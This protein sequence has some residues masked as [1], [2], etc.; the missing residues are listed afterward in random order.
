ML[1][2]PAI[3]PVALS[4]GPLQ[5]HWY[6]IMYMLAFIGAY[7]LALRNSQRPWSP[8]RKPQVEDLIFYGAWGVILGGRLGGE[9]R[10]RGRRT[11]QHLGCS[12]HLI[13]CCRRRRRR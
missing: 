5:V 8:I 11:H 9:S 12:D 10:H 1:S 6:G 7:F 13:R 3:D 4:I 2:Y